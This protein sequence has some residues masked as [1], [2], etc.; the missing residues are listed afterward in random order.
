MVSM[1]PCIHENPFY[2]SSEC[3]SDDLG[4]RLPRPLSQCATSRSRLPGIPHVT[5]VECNAAPCAPLPSLYLWNRACFDISVTMET[6]P[7][8]TT[9]TELHCRLNNNQ[10]ALNSRHLRASSDGPIPGR[11]QV[12]TKEGLEIA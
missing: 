11:N 1:Y 2:P 8:A 6:R 4:V 7:G 12:L 10:T 3:S 5:P 9:A